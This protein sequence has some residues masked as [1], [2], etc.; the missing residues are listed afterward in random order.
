MH[1]CN[2]HQPSKRVAKKKDFFQRHVPPS[3]GRFDEPDPEPAYP[4]VD[5][6]QNRKLSQCQQSADSIQDLKKIMTERE[7]MM[8]GYLQPWLTT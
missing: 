1:F 7:D 2:P 4:G 3:S 8:E 6:N 5:S